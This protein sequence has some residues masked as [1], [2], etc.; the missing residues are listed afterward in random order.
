MLR[1]EAREAVPIINDTLAVLL[2]AGPVRGRSG[3]DLRTAI[4]RIRAYTEL[5]L[6]N[7]QIGPPLIECFMLARQAGV[8]REEF[9]HARQAAKA[10]NPISVGALVIRNS[11]VE[12]CLAVECRIIA[13]MRFISRHDIDN[14]RVEMNDAFNVIIDEIAETMEAMTYRALITMHAALINFLTETAR[15]LPRMLRYSFAGTMPT[16]VMAH[17]LYG[18]AGRADQ[19][20]YENRIIHPAFALRQGRALSE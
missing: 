6:Y 1:D 19:L 17:R 2:A 5:W 4:G 3:S 18:D 9:G 20:R 16:L 15:P 8:T 11:I 12:L 13:D 7:D 10:F 14:L